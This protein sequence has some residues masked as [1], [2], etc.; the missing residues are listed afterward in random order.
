MTTQTLQQKLRAELEIIE[1]IIDTLP[2][3]GNTS[4][5]CQKMTLINAVNNLDSAINGIEDED[6]KEGWND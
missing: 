6:L 2:Q 3:K 4:E 5:D 1:K